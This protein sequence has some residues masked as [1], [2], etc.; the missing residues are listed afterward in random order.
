[1]S[2]NYDDMMKLYQQMSNPQYVPSSR[3]S[4]SPGSVLATD[5]R[6]QPIQ[7]GSIV[8]IIP[9]GHW[10]DGKTFIVK[11]GTVNPHDPSRTEIGPTPSGDRI[12]VRYVEV[13]STPKANKPK[14][15]AS[16]LSLDSVILSE[17]KKE[18]I[19]AA[20]GQVEHHQTIFEKWGFGQVFEKGTA[21]SLLFWGTPGT[22]KSLCAQ[23]IAE[24]L[25]H[26]LKT[27]GAGEVESSEPGGAERTIQ[28]LFATAKQSQ[29]VLLFDE[30]DSLLMDRN[31]VGPIIGATINCLLG[32]I[33]HFTGVVIFTTNRL[34]KLD[35]A[36]ER[37]LSAKIEFPFPD[38]DQ[39]LAIWKR[40]L[41]KEA[42]L[43]KDVVL[44]TLAEVPL[45]GGNIKNAVLNA[46]RMA[47]YQRAKALSQEHFHQAIAQEQAAQADWQHQYGRYDHTQPLGP[48]YARH[49][50]GGVKVS[51]AARFQARRKA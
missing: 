7:A 41:P 50:R 17:D 49:D 16:K 22:G 51:A 48:E 13:V 8:R 27:I 10:D 15:V 19:K 32:E 1:M 23:A 29:D 34:G 37:R 12:Y 3:A 39:R 30:C 43:A 40:M 9:C 33:E 31:E 24:T 2:S 5:R 18:A 35:P 11:E 20:L 36:L 45:A 38:K 47:A 21:I 14:A 6:G 28:E 42:P 46:A 26:K 44:E 4:S 25:G